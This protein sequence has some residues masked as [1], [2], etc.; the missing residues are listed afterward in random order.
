MQVRRRGYKLGENKVLL[1]VYL[2]LPRV[3][4]VWNI[5]PSMLQL[6]EFR[7]LFAAAQLKLDLSR[8]GIWS[9]ILTHFT[10]VFLHQTLCR[11]MK[12]LEPGLAI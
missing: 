12:H 6:H 8:L 4:C 5:S 1:A 7:N 10:R 2:Y 11:K 3:A 9:F